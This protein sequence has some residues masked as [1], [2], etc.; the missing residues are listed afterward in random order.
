MKNKTRVKLIQDIEIKQIGLTLNLTD[1]DGYEE[2]GWVDSFPYDNCLKV[3][4]SNL[5]A[6]YI[7]HRF[8][9]DPQLHTLGYEEDRKNN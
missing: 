4:L 2:V 9:K 6:N 1:K 8:T 5:I 3:V 7:D